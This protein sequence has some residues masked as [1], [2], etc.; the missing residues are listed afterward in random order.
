MK[1]FFAAPESFLP[2]ALTAFGSH[3][4]R[5]FQEAV[6]R[7][8]S[9]GLAI[10]VNRFGCARFLRHCRAERQG[11]NHSSN[12][13]QIADPSAAQRVGRCSMTSS[14]ALETVS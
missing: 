9:Q 13:N 4:S 7:G 6:E 8:A 3:A 11:R 2:S 10:L 1:L 14:E 12:K 5:L